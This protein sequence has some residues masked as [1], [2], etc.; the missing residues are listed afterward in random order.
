MQLSFL[1]VTKNRPID[2]A[3]T[4]SKLKILMNLSIHEVL[5]CIDGCSKTEAIVP[6]FNW[7]NWTINSKSMSASPARSVLYKKAKGKIF[8]GLDDDAHPISDNFISQVENEFQQNNN[9]GIIAFQEI[10]GLFNTDDDA[11]KKVNMGESYLTNDFI[12]CGFA[13][14]KEVYDAINGFPVW[15]DIY[16]EESAVAIEVLDLGFQI[17]YQPSIVINHRID[18]EKR[19][20]QGRNYFRFEKQLR[21]ELRYYLVYYPKPTFKILKLL[22]HNFKK[23]G[24]TDINYFKSFIKICYLTVF[25]LFNILKFRRPVKKITIENKLNLKSLKY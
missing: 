21:N 5:V 25:Q 19:K 17:L 11:L 2:L 23:Y 4:L 20:Q 10:K 3:L 16:G 24:L 12:G 18:T 7:V 15:M 6:E 13:I 22:M 1:I 14:K 9:L 8:I